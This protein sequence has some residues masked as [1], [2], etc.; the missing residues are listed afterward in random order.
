[1]LDDFL[2]RSRRH[3]VTQ[4]SDLITFEDLRAL[5]AELQ[6]AP[7][8]GVIPLSEDGRQINVCADLQAPYVVTADTVLTIAFGVGAHRDVV[9]M[10]G[11][12]LLQA[13][14]SRCLD[15]RRLEETCRDREGTLDTVIVGTT[16]HA[17]HK[18]V[19][20]ENVS[21]C[22]HVTCYVVRHPS[23][24]LAI[25]S[26][27]ILFRCSDVECLERD[28]TDA[29]PEAPP[30]SGVRPLDD[31]GDGREQGER[32]HGRRDQQ[33][34]MRADE[35]RRRRPDLVPPLIRA[36]R[37]EVPNAV[38]SR[39]AAKLEGRAIPPTTASMPDGHEDVAADASS[40][41]GTLTCIICF[42]GDKSH[43][44]V[45]C[46][47]QCACRACSSFSPSVLF[48]EGKWTRGFVCMLRDVCSSVLISFETLRQG[49]NGHGDSCVDT[50]GGIQPRG[51]ASVPCDGARGRGERA[52]TLGS[53][54]A[55]VPT[56]TCT[57]L[58]TTP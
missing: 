15:R 21:N 56:T 13:F 46:G 16:R 20:H 14:A 1:M 48:A 41:G 40:V 18:V 7:L 33:R 29:A 25:V 39:R 26:I 28:V 22:D 36:S 47:H 50:L 58:R 24:D 12:M 30:S 42:L 51:C 11:E 3:L 57:V 9:R 19:L 27:N 38:L 2:T 54:P 35:K 6:Q 53:R 10:T 55:T 34:R 49:C 31:S 52:R 8:P 17:A 23:D 44:A 43:L 45:P 32:R 4:R 5:T 37:A